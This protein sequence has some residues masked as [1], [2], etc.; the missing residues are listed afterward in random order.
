MS[1][2]PTRTFYIL[3]GNTLIASVTNAFVW[4]TITFWV[5]LETNSVL[6]TSYVAGIFAVANMV[7]ALFFGTIVDRNRKKTAMLYSS[8]ASL[9]FYVIGT[10]LY[11]LQDPSIFKEPSSIML[12]SV[13][14]ILILGSVAGNLRTI[15]LTTSVTLLFSENR[16]RAN[17]MI[18]AVSGISFALT[19]ALSGLTMG[20]FGIGIALIA[21][22]VATGVGLAHLLTISL[23]EPTISR[24]NESPKY[25]D[26]KETVVIMSGITGLFSLIFF[27]TFN[28]FLSG[29]SAGLMDPYGLSLM[30]V[31]A[32]GLMFSVLIIGSSVIAKFG[33]G[34]NPVRQILLANAIMWLVC[35]FFVIQP[36]VLLLGTGIFIWMITVP[37]IEAAESTILQKV[38]PYDRQGRVLGLALTIESAASPITT[39]L[40]G[41]IAQFF[42]I[43][44][45]TTGAGVTLI[46]DWFGVGPD[47][48]IA[49]VFIAS[50]VIGLIVTLLAL[51]S[52]SYR[53]LS[54]QF[55]QST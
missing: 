16:D 11:F 22:I 6:A 20:F 12:W 37:F 45:M 24:S 46:G 28:N 4:F 51:R 36:S 15:A 53:L 25:I 27:S 38:V 19:S 52:R 2:N 50:G 32:W 18:G 39:F 13:V 55:T 5:F 43:P 42:F 48:G 26:F 21:A 35:I 54:K 7:S 30:S 3:L 10:A 49:L 41:P 29:I 23:P 9:L 33:L 1:F 31:Q 34:V 17:G 40:I 44:F 8:A 14:I 47:R